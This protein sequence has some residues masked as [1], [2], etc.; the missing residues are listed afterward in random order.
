MYYE[1]DRCVLKDQHSE[2]FGK[3]TNFR[4]NR[5][6][7]SAELLIMDNSGLGK[8]RLGITIIMQERVGALLM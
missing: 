2:M 5:R 8:D 3:Q 4:G 1:V 6:G 7:D